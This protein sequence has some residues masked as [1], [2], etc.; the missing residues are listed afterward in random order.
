VL[1]A[2]TAL[3]FALKEQGWKFEMGAGVVEAEKT[4]WENNYMSQKV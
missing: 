4:F 1:I 2:I 3:E